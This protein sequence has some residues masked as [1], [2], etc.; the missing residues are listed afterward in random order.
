MEYTNGIGFVN[1]SAT[2]M[3]VPS[4]RFDISSVSINESFSPLFGVDVTTKNNLTLG[5]KFI[6]SRVL[7]LSL[8]AI[9]LVETHT[10][11]IAF[12]LGYKIV[13]F[14]LLERLFDGGKKAR[15]KK[16]DGEEKSTGGSDINLRAD[17]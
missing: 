5:A 10:E 9:Q 8:T 7:N 4:S 13:N 2:N 11:E 16:K 15:K 1:N 3:P 12:N 17:F 14:K 6:K